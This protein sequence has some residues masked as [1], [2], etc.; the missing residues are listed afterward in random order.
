VC[1]TQGACPTLRQACGSLSAFLSTFSPFLQI[2]YQH[3]I[4]SE[5]AIWAWNKEVSKKDKKKMNGE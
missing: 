2:F 4:V 3:D 5:D 1:S